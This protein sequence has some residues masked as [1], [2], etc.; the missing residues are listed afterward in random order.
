M[1]TPAQAN[2]RWKNNTAAATQTWQDGVQGYSGD[3]AGATVSQG[4][5]YLSGVQQAY[6]A[7]LWQQGVQKVGTQ[8]WKSRTVA[9][10]ANFS[11]GVNAAGERQLSA[12]TKILNAEATIVGGLSPRGDFAAN[13][14][15]M[16]SVV[17]Q[18]HALKGQ[19]GAS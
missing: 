3:W 9:K 19:L 6:S 4:P 1:K 15:R 10:A 5:A 14:A 11:V 7:G 2:S 18:L 16:N 8:G 17:D 13:K 12:I